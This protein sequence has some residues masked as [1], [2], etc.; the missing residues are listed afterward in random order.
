MVE[1]LAEAIS[2]D[3]KGEASRMLIKSRHAKHVVNERRRNFLKGAAL[4]GAGTVVAGAT[5]LA[6]I[7]DGAKAQGSPIPIGGITPLTGP[8]C[9]VGRGGQARPRDGVRGSQRHGRDPWPPRRAG[10]RRQQEPQR[11]R[12]GI[13]GQSPDRQAR[14]SRHHQRPQYR[15]E[16][17][18]V[19]PRCRCV[20][21]V[22]SHQYVATARRMD[23]KQPGASIRRSS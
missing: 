12:S 10:L 4:A 1:A 19:R 22:H 18:R 14:G 20:R 23:R 9:A 7:N 15:L 11:R 21:D 16:Q 8:R 13:R 6:D 5:T 17:R 3:D 2:T